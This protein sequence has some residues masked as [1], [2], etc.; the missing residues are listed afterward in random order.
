MTAVSPTA[1]SPTD[2][3]AIADIYDGVFPAHVQEHY[4]QRRVRYIRQHAPA[5]TAIDVGAGTGIL[6]ERLADAGLDVVA[7]DPFPGMLEQLRRRRPGVQ[8]VVAHGEAIPFP[9]DSFDLAYSVAVMHHI[10]D[11]GK[12][13][14]TLAEMVRVTRQGGRIVIWDHNP[15]NPYWPNLMKRVP[16]D[17]GSER[18]ASM[19]ELLAG[20]T[21][22]G[23]T[24]ERADRLGMMPEFMPQALLPWAALLERGVEATPG[25]RSYCAHNVIVASKE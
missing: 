23:A 8:T 10:A 9:D 20:L 16:Q 25:L 3:D 11:P 2:F 21:A 13:R 5:A 18:L 22:A 7:L 1:G 19:E 17:V 4:L 6:A 24:I 14:R 15:R 12:V